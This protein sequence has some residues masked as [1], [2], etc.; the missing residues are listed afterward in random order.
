MSQGRKLIVND[1]VIQSRN[2]EQAEQ[3]RGRHF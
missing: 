2:Q 1:F 3:H